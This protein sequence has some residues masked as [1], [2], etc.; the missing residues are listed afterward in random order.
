MCLEVGVHPNAWQKGDR[1]PLH[2]AVANSG[3]PGVIKAL[4]DAG[5]EAYQR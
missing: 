5:A 4:I 3:D 1:T 2:N